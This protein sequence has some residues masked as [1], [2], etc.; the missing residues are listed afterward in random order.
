MEIDEH[1][2]Q[3][4]ESLSRIP[5]RGL[6]RVFHSH[7][8][9]GSAIISGMILPAPYWQ[10][11][12]GN[13]RLFCGDCLDILPLLEAGSVDAVVTSPRYNVGIEYGEV[14]DRTPWPDYYA[15][16][17]AFLRLFRKRYDLARKLLPRLA[18]E[19]RRW[20]TNSTRFARLK[21]S[22]K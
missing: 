22:C 1:T 18:H 10:S 5:L 17:R 19:L 14:N 12:C 13:H 6:C 20:Q 21:D 7:F 4:R 2:R 15:E 16:M 11:P 9:P 8:P 3:G